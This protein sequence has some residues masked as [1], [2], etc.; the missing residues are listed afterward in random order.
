MSLTQYFEKDVHIY[1]AYLVLCG[2]MNM[3]SFK[4]SVQWIEIHRSMLCGIP[5]STRIDL[6]HWQSRRH[7]GLSSGH[8]K[9]ITMV[10]LSILVMLIKARFYQSVRQCLY[11]SVTGTT[12]MSKC[13]LCGSRNWILNWGW[14][15]KNTMHTLKKIGTD[16][17]L[18]V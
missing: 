8:E 14:C 11:F 4:N 3:I 7:C 10:D 15:T 16:P 6:P 5:P 18:L 12:G 2:Y 1:Y 9:I 13:I 17:A